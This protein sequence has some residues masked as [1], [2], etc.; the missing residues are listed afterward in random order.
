M[1]GNEAATRISSITTASNGTDSTRSSTTVKPSMPLT[2][3]STPRGSNMHITTDDTD[4]RR[5]LS[6]DDSSVSPTSTTATRGA[7]S[8]PS[9]TFNAT[10]TMGKD[11]RLS[12][13]TNYRRDLSVLEPTR[14]QTLSSF[15]QNSHPVGSPG[16]QSATWISSGGA[17]PGASPR[18]MPTSFY[19]DSSDSL[20]MASQ[21]SPGLPSVAGR[22]GTGSGSVYPDYA[23]A[24]YYD[25]DGRR[26]SAASI[27]TTAS[28]QGSK[29][30]VNRGGFRKLQGFFG[31]EFPGRDSSESS[32]PISVP[33]KDQRSRSY[34]HGRPNQRDR[35]Y[36]NATDREPSPSSRPRTPVPNPEVVPFLYQDNT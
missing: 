8:P 29:T 24:L 34:S 10:G 12:D 19:N 25:I 33:G 9:A 11:R 3:V 16:A 21:F 17:P 2:S 1:T 27:V 18:G 32:L 6:K 22:P 31:E 35:N 15:P 20:S 23:D 4:R 28:S 14:S 30:S 5:R 13:F 7:L 36:S 26:P